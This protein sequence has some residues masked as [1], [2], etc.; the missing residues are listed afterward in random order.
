MRSAG[1]R[2]LR[3]GVGVI[4]VEVGR[5]VPGSDALQPELATWRGFLIGNRSVLLV[6]IEPCG[7]WEGAALKRRPLADLAMHIEDLPPRRGI[8]RLVRLSLGDGDATSH[9]ETAKYKRAM[10]GRA[11]FRTRLP[12]EAHKRHGHGYPSRPFRIGARRQT[13]ILG[14]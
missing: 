6:S 13:A 12:R 11:L 2:Q 9:E 14:S 5:V 10:H 8:G 1:L 3:Q 7:D 4:L